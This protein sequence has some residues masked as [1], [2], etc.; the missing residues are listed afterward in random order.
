MLEFIIALLM[1]LGLYSG[2]MDALK[3]DAASIDIIKAN[4][5]YEEFGGDKE[6]D[7]LFKSE[8]SQDQIVIGI[9]PN[10][11]SQEEERQN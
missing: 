3:L 7:S 11:P 1:S 4:A 8:T 9:D 2:D 5:A 6:F 10:P